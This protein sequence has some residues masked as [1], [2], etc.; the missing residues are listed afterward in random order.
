M[1]SAFHAKLRWLIREKRSAEAT[2][3]PEV[4]PGW[5]YP[6][7][8]VTLLSTPLR[9]Q[10][11]TIIWQRTSLS[12]SLFTE[13]YQTPVNRFAELVQEL[14][15][16][17][18]H[19]HSHAGGLLDHSL[20]VMAFA[21]KMRQ[22]H[23][24]PT[25]A[26]PE[27]QAKEAE[28]WTAG[29]IYA[30]LL[31]DVGK[32]IT[33]I[34][35]TTDDNQRWFPWQGTLQKP[36]R[37]KYSK[38]RDYQLHPTIASLLAVT[39]LPACALNWLGQ[40]QELTETFM[41]CISGHYDRAGIIGE[42]VQEADRAS[43]A[44]FMG[45]NASQALQRPQPSLPQ[46]IL[47]ALR[48]LIRTT[49]KLSHPGSGSDGWL[50][51]D[52][53]WLV[54]KTTADRVRAWLLQQG[55]TGVPD[56][57]PRLFDEM[58][59]HGLILPTSEGK[60]VWACTITADSGWTPGSLTLL[61]LSPAKIWPSQEDRPG[62]FAGNV[63]PAVET[64]FR[65]IKTVSEA[66]DRA[67]PSAAPVSSE[68]MLA[69]LTFSLFAPPELYHRESPQETKGVMEGS[70]VMQ[71]GAAIS[72]A[73]APEPVKLSRSENNAPASGNTFISWLK[74]GIRSRKIAVN[75]TLALVHMVEGKAFLVSPGIFQL[76]IKSTTGETESEE[77]KQV[78]KSFQK[79]A[80]HYRSE[81]GINIFT[82]EVRGPRKTRRVRG[83]LF[84]KPGDIFDNAIPEDNP[85]LSVMPIL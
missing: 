78:Q 9:Q 26:A 34:E 56:S 82:C 70:S 1:H 41:Y 73:D 80:I 79:L 50:T 76:F 19:H 54:S 5:L 11:M 47:T 83:Y 13:L 75:D 3:S 64:A 44:Q 17:E 28:A 45:A 32:I 58:Q 20:E 61:R 8:A 68:N 7:S 66:K 25:G 59:V 31:H 12:G 72:T 21:A 49:F 30:A 16:S 60:A 2:T 52:S 4:K 24:L 46:Q 36:Y 10:L 38:Q 81:K 39:I 51:E 29:V 48:E 77:W 74:E 69:D 37:L 62:V 15:A 63:S 14:P 53:L 67:L 18:Y 57:N 6:Q 65:E 33:D 85:F 43:V 84:D 55:I 40:Y 35:V 22:R 42:L 71:T 27:D 23:L